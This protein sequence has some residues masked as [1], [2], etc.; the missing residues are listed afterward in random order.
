MLM[1]DL[2]VARNEWPVGIVINAIKGIDNRVRKVEVRITRDGKP[3]TYTRPIS[4]LV[5]LLHND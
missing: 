5:H 3:T 1:K 2:S 4:E